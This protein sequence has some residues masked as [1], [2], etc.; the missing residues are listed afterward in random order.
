MGLIGGLQIVE[1]LY[2]VEV[3]VVMM[4]PAALESPILRKEWLY[5]RQQGVSIYPIKTSSEIDFSILPRWMCRVHWY[6][7]QYE[8]AMFRN[9]LSRPDKKR[10]VPF[11]VSDLLSD[12]VPRHTNLTSY[13][14]NSLTKNSRNLFPSWLVYGEQVA[15]ERLL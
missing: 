1:E 7:L 11:M 15:M 14:Q 6:D 8:Q 9:V 4:T 2:T 10:Y 3:M 12:F 13:V 5:A